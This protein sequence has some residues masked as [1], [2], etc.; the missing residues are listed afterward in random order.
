[1]GEG[2][3]LH[4]GA[5]RPGD[6]AL[7]G[8]ATRYVDR[9]TGIDERTREDYHREIR[10][11]LS[12]LRHTDPAGNQRAATICNLTQ[13]DVTDWVRAEEA[14]EKDAEDPEK[15][16]RRPA[17]P[18]SIANR[19]GQDDRGHPQRRPVAVTTGLGPR[20]PA[21]GPDIRSTPAH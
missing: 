12:V 10:L 15:W 13:D 6:V 1:M 21:A 14:G 4:R 3:G 8:Y 9:L 11:H 18:K 5:G 16:A 19:H 17:D 20:F 2:S 7:D